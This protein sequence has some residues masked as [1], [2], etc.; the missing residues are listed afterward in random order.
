M[1]YYRRAIA[2]EFVDA[3]RGGRG[4]VLR[5]AIFVPESE[6]KIN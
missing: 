6:K 4:S 5:I 2:V 3:R 1:Q